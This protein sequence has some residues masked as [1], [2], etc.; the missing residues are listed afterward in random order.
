MR[1]WRFSR[2]LFSL[3]VF[4]VI[5]G[6]LVALGCGDGGGSDPA[7]FEEAT[8]ADFSGSNFSFTASFL[9]ASFADQR[10]SLVF[11]TAV[12]N[13]VPFTMTFSGEP[14]TVITGTGIVGSIQ[15]RVDAITEDGASVMSTQIGNVVFEVG[16]VAYTLEAEISKDNGF[17]TFRFT[18][19][20]TGAMLELTN[21]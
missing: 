4:L 11:G 20:V 14:T 18:N 6:S 16:T 9:D 1:H 8:V 15:L 3:T 17:F 19:P 13:T 7:P 21:F 2:G 5:T 12:D 10:V